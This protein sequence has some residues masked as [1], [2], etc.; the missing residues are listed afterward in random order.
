M[1]IAEVVQLRPADV[2]QRGDLDLGD[3]RRVHRE[4]PLHADPET[5]LADGERLLDAAPLAPHDGALEHLHPLAVALDDPDVDLD[6]V[7]WAELGDVV[8]Q[9]VAVDRFGGVH[10]RRPSVTPAQCRTEHR[11]RAQTGPARRWR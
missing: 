5:H 4:G 1:A 3:R 2:A 9:A 10:E 11:S 6:G 8:A 7:A